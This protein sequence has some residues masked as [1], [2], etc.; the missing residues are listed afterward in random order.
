MVEWLLY[1]SVSVQV[2]VQGAVYWTEV[3]ARADIHML[4]G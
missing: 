3:W 1:V 2:R 4:L